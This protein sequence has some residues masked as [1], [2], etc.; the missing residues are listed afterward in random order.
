MP[1][2]RTIVRWTGLGLLAA[3]SSRAL[4]CVAATALLLPSPTR[5]DTSSVLLERD[6]SYHHIIVRQT[7]TRRLLQFDNT[8]QGSISL[9][10]PLT[11]AIPY[12]YYIHNAFALEPAIRSVLVIGLGSATVPRSLLHY[13]PAVRVTVA[14]IDPV[15]RAATEA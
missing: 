3:R 4:A 11:G 10:D 15:A 1:R 9:T 7:D 8:L 12:T 6:T 5:A 13:Y 14:E 2:V